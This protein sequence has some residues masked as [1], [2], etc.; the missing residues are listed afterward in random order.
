MN[1]N[2][3][4]HHGVLG[5]KWGVRRYQNKDGSLTKAGI[6]KYGTKTNFNKVQAAK[7]AAANAPKIEKARKER[8]KANART[9]AEIAKYKKQISKVSPDKTTTTSNKTK[10]IKDMS[11]AEL[12]KVIDRKRLENTYRELTPQQ[13]N[14][15][16]SFVKKTSDLVINKWVIPAAEDLGKQAVKS[17]MAKGINSLF[18]F[19]GESRVYANNKKKN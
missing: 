4:Y 1:Q 17:M 11:D 5:Q 9:E 13:V 2:E 18:E 16:K 6:K 15:G 12:Q 7:K 10:S 3:L 8:E 14:K 19:E